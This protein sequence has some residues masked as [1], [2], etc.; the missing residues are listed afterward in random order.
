MW[1]FKQNIYLEIEFLCLLSLTSVY[2]I[3]RGRLGLSIFIS[4]M[5]WQAVCFVVQICFRQANSCVLRKENCV[6]RHANFEFQQANTVC[7]VIQIL[8]FVRQTAGWFVRKTVGFVSW[9]YRSEWKAAFETSFLFYFDLL[10]GKLLLDCIQTSIS[11]EKFYVKNL[12]V[13]SSLFVF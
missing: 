7:F 1:F 5:I 2:L 11:L 6:L 4:H 8:C 10:R 12:L 3:I 13:A 9:L